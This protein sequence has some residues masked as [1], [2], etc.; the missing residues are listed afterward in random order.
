VA[1]DDD[2]LATLRLAY[3]D[4]VRERDRLRDARASITSQLGLPASAGIAI[5]VVGALQEDVDGAW[6]VIASA[7]LLVM[8]VTSIAFSRLAPYRKLRADRKV[9]VGGDA[10]AGEEK[11][12]EDMIELERGLYGSLEKA[13]EAELAALYAVQLLFVAIIGVLVLGL[14]TS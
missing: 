8:V 11:W 13:L 12:L 3:E 2:K 1:T 5:G 6:L 10:E 14:V 4:V 9:K 7:L